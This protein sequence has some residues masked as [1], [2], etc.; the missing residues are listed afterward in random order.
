MIRNN[1]AKL[2]IDRGIKATMLAEKTGIAKSTL[3]KISNNA[4]AKI[5]YSTIN[6]ICSVLRITPS[7]F[8]EYTPINCSYNFE[9]TDDFV[10]TLVVDTS[11]E[12]E[13]KIFGSITFTKNEMKISKIEYEGVLKHLI[14]NNENSDYTLMF[15]GELAPITGINLSIFDEIPISFQTDIEEEFSDYV[16]E[17][18]KKQ[19]REVIRIKEIDFG[20][21]GANIKITLK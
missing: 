11:R 1:L 13:F 7:D 16:Q 12:L 9:I 5:E 8:F 3:S 21:Y 17:A 20:T 15:E 6:S 10:P 18:T 14:T 2:L 4:T 19:L